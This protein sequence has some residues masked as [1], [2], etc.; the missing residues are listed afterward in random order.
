MTM[1]QELHI[2]PSEE[3]LTT[4][5]LPSLSPVDSIPMHS[6]HPW[7]QRQSSP[8]QA[9]RDFQVMPDYVRANPSGYTYLCRLELKAENT[10]PVCVWVKV[11]DGKS[12]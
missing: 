3:F 4:F 5:E 6:I 2:A 11:E 7:E 1:A 12:S 8:F 9:L 10:L